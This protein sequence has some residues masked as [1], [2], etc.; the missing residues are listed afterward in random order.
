LGFETR[1]TRKAIFRGQRLEILSWFV[2]HELARKADWLIKYA[3]FNREV[4]PDCVE[5]V[6]GPLSVAGCPLSEKRRGVLEGPM[7][8]TTPLEET[9]SRAHLAGISYLEKFSL[10]WSVFLSQGGFFIL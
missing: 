2:N 7:L 1:L 9:Q 5:N 3:G 8:L 10:R 4:T 6:I